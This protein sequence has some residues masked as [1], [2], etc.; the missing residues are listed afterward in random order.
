M[1]LKCSKGCG[2]NTFVQEKSIYATLDEKGE[3][4]YTEDTEV[5]PGGAIVCVK[6]S[7]PA[8]VKED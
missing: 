1:R 8:E 2:S 3:T 7:A 6:C 4:L 5:Q